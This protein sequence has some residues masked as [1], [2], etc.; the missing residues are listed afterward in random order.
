MKI[1]PDSIKEGV[2][3]ALISWFEEYPIST[4]N[5]LEDALIAAFAKWLEGHS[6][7]IIEAIAK[8][9]G[10]DWMNKYLPTPA[11]KEAFRRELSCPQGNRSGLSR[12]SIPGWTDRF[13]CLPRNGGKDA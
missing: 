4:R 2:E 11:E 13:Y 9:A 6:K 7:E 10:A 1:T 8:H 3:R 12:L 5:I